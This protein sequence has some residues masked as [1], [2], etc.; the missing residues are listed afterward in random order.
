MSRLAP[1]LHGGPLI[2]DG[3]W[4]TQLQALGLA[5]GELPDKW[6]IE[7]AD[8]VAAVAR[9]YVEAGSEIVLTN[10]FRANGITLQEAGMAGSIEAINRRGVEISREAAAGRARVVAS[11]GPTGKMLL[12][13]D[14]TPEQVRA[15]FLAQALAL[16]AAQPDALLCET[17][18][19]LEEAEIALS[20]ALETGL[21]VIVSFAFDTGKNKDRTMTGLTPEKAAAAIA[22]AG[23]DAIGANCGAGIEFFASLAA[24][25]RSACQLPVWIK[26]NAGLPRMEQGRVVY[27][28]SA[29]AFASHFD[30]LQQAGTSFAGG[31]CGTG[32]EFITALRKQRDAG[33][34]APC[35]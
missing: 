19:E 12:A 26:A 16:A 14:V 3:A 9:A 7:H 32:P 13:G 24:R 28:A 18:S 23:A 6:N 31:C 2:T 15:A 21:P 29:D 11:I 17:F 20:A 34:S 8:H 35:A 1:W 27:D 33:R 5:P 4:G 10:T 25:F 22:A 30:A